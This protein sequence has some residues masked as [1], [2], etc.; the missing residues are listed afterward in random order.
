MS[1]YLIKLFPIGKFFFGGDMTFSVGM[2]VP[3]NED[4]NLSEKDIKQVEFN[5]RYSNYIIKSEKFPQ[6]TTLLGMLRFLLLR[7]NKS[8]FSDNQIVSD[9]KGEIAK[10]IGQSSFTSQNDGSENNYGKIKKISPC[11]LMFHDD[12]YTR[13]PMDYGLEKIVLSN[14]QS[15]SN[16]CYYNDKK[17][18][19][20]TIIAK[21][22]NENRPIYYSAKEGG[23]PNY[24]CSNIANSS[25]FEEDEIFIKDQRI[26][27]SRNIDTGITEDNA[28]FKQVN[29]RLADGY[30]FAL[31]A[32][33]DEDILSYSNEIVSLGADSSQFSI[34]IEK[35]DTFP[36]IPIIKTDVCVEGGEYKVVLKSPAL[37]DKTIVFDYA[38][39]ETIPFKYMKTNINYNPE[40]YHRVSGKIDHSDRV[41]LYQTGSVF[42]FISKDK[43][44]AFV[45]GLNIHN[46]YRQ[47]GYNYFEMI[48]MNNN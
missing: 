27:I 42:Y 28:L 26:G 32:S 18:N 12:I 34:K 19:L 2:T 13:L 40:D 48:S 20:S 36:E 39:A 43:A 15:K 24:Y 37:V 7:N 41:V 21:T 31:Y 9:K 16:V 5:S 29:Y 33:I 17:L 30:C 14:D 1:N 8:L 4:N 46:D 10:L 11:F 38:I 35:L 23:I 44:D 3:K 6:Q 25:I 45:K 22:D 47:I